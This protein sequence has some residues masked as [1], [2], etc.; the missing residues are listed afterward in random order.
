MV[1]GSGRPTVKATSTENEKNKSSQRRELDVPTPFSGCFCSTRGRYLPLG[2]STGPCPC[3]HD[4]GPTTA[5]PQETPRWLLPSRPHVSQPAVWP[6]ARL[7]PPTQV[8]P[9]RQRPMRPCCYRPGTAAPCK[10]GSNPSVQVRTFAPICVSSW[11]YAQTCGQAPMH[12]GMPWR[13]LVQVTR[14]HYR[15]RTGG[16]CSA[17]TDPGQT[18][19]LAALMYRKYCPV[20]HAYL[21]GSPLFLAIVPNSRVGQSIGERGKWPWPMGA[22]CSWPAAIGR[23]CV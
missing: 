10:R 14:D 4:H 15:R 20:W 8:C 13:W 16:F 5:A 6:C 18:S 17:G 3:S 11:A 2:D 1:P 7:P 9:C 12:G 23:A 22:W 21:L 19:A